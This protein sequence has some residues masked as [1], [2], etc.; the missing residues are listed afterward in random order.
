M[1]HGYN[2]KRAKVINDGYL[3]EYFLKEILLL[4]EILMKFGKNYRATPRT[5]NMGSWA[6]GYMEKLSEMKEYEKG[7][8]GRNRKKSHF[9][10]D[11]KRNI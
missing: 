4:A 7:I 11:I 2:Y 5:R 3:R 1:E 9:S 6:K 8:S 10:R